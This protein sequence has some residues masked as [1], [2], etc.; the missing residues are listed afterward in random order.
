VKVTHVTLVRLNSYHYY[1]TLKPAWAGRF[2][3][4]PNGF[5]LSPLGVS[6]H[7]S[8]GLETPQSAHRFSEKN[9]K[10]AGKLSRIWVLVS[11][12]VL[13]L[14]RSQCFRRLSFLV[15]WLC[16]SAGYDWHD[17]TDRGLEG[18]LHWNSA[19]KFRVR[20]PPPAWEFS[21][22]LPCPWRSTEWPARKDPRS[23]FHSVNCS[24]VCRMCPPIAS[25]APVLH[26]PRK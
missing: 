16:E 14:P 5:D 1:R 23:L 8:D 2:D 6:L 20:H 26:R 4:L 22:P 11:S 17:K 9:L 19:S 13:R 15:L 3:L 25:L 24:G 18:K 10:L 21:F 12:R 7:W